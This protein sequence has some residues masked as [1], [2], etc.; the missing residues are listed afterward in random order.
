[1]EGYPG[2]ALAIDQQRQDRG[3]GSV[4]PFD[5]AVDHRGAQPESSEVP[6]DRK[7]TEEDK[8]KCSVPWQAML[9]ILRQP[10]RPNLG[11]SECTVAC[12]GGH[13]RGA[14]IRCGP[15]PAAPMPPASPAM[16][17]L[18]TAAHNS[19]HLYNRASSF[20]SMTTGRLSLPTAGA[21]AEGVGM[22]T[23]TAIL[24]TAI[25]RLAVL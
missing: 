19:L 9:G 16:S 6:I 8:A 10:I 25:W 7:S 12:M 11:R 1:M 14:R 13:G 5:C 18:F 15:L 2:F 21:S 17:A 24:V 23:R 3:I 20:G 4:C 22:S